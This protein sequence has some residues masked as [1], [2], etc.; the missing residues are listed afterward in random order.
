MPILWDHKN[1]DCFNRN[2][3]VAV[4]QWLKEGLFEKNKQINLTNL[5]VSWTFS[6][7]SCS[8]FGRGWTCIFEYAWHLQIWHSSSPWELTW[9]SSWWSQEN[10]SSLLFSPCTC[11]TP[12]RPRC[13]RWLVGYFGS[14]WRIPGEMNLEWELKID[15][16]ESRL[17]H[18]GFFL[19]DSTMS[20]FLLKRLPRNKSLKHVQSWIVTANPQ[21][22]FHL[23]NF[24]HILWRKKKNKSND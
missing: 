7:E 22:R 20:A 13:G 6:P 5:A 23:S 1:G 24:F 3:P 4:A 9:V 14:K 17:K 2:G 21:K 10:P 11:L 18:G 12:L 19:K 15:S 16:N 8:Y